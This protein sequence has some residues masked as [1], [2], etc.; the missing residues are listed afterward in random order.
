M[1]TA[2]GLG[3]VTLIFLYGLIMLINEYFWRSSDTVL[4]L[5]A[6]VCLGSLVA[7]LVIAWRKK[8]GRWAGG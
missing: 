2:V 5:L 7:L 8:I 6:L 3:V 4:A 1:G